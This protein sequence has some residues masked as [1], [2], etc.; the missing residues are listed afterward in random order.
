MTTRQKWWE[1]H[2]KNPHV[3]D[4]FEKFTF[5]AINKGHKNCSAWL[6][7][8]RIRWE[9]TIET[10]GNDFKISNDFIAHYARYFM[11]LHPEHEGFFRTKPLKEDI[12]GS[13]G[14]CLRFRTL[15]NPVR[16]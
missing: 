4:L 3:W 7:V 9:T 5:Q 12:R 14:E 15:E 16:A 10:T 6:V 1:W 8:N 11:M 2:L 13:D